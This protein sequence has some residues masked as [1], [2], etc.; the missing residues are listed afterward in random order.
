MTS[1]NCKNDHLEYD[2]YINLKHDCIEML[3]KSAY[4]CFGF[5]MPHT[6]LHCNNIIINIIIL[7]S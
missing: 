3:V 5:N 4:Y 6:T 2:A 1:F 7:I